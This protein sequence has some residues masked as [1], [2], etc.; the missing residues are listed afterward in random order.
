MYEVGGRFCL[1][2]TLIRVMGTTRKY[3]AFDI[4]TA[5]LPE[6]D[7]RSC[8]PLGISCAATLLADS[9]QPKLWHGGNDRARPADR[10]SREE[11]AELVRYLVERTKQGCTVVTWNGV[12]F[13]LD[14]L[15]EE[16]G[17]LETCRTLALAHVD[18]MFHVLCKLGY[19]VSLDAAARGMGVDGKPEGMNGKL[20]PSLWAEGKREEVL[21]YVGQDV[22]TT[23]AL[24][25]VC[26]SCGVFRWV[27]RS[28]RLRTMS[29]SQGWLA[30]EEA[31]EL[32]LPD[33]SWMDE[34]WSRTKFTAWM[35]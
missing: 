5:K 13:D 32:P 31:L 6:G 2:I 9:D 22:R 18:M 14:V 3:L 11:A 26:E 35:G 8:R 1:P 29:L 12:G 21:R 7:W 16:S 33:T 30:V 17:L 4:E 23:L 28:G 19:G 34:P 24:A 25:T 20:A 10:M 15:A 27:A